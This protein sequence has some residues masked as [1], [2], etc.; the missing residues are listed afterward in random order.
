MALMWLS[1]DSFRTV[2]WIAVIP[3]FVA[4][5]LILVAVH[6]P[7]RPPARRVLANPLTWSELNRLSSAFW[8]VVAVAV[9]FTLARFSEAFLVLRAQSVGL[10]VMLVPAVLVIMN[11]AYTFAAY[12]AGALSDQLER[13]ILLAA[14]ICL[15]IAAHLVLA[16]MPN[17]AGIAAGAALWGLH[18]AF[19]QGI[20]AALVADTVSA[21]LRGTAYGLFNML[22][23]IAMLAASVM[24]GLLWDLVG[25]QATFVS[26]AAL[27]ALSGGGLFAVRRKVG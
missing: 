13:P 5:I 1:A 16:Y 14:A 7:S 18:M 2:F 8:L 10:P 22:T 26:G 27:A 12:P 11:V 4:F 17:I 25:P 24:A 6:E 3:A 20:Y 19:S 23:G 21:E 9:V 15:L